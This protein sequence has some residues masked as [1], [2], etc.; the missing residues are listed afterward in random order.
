MSIRLLSIFLVFFTAN[1]AHAQPVLYEFTAT[2]SLEVRGDPLVDEFFEVAANQHFYAPATTISGSFLYDNAFPVTPVG[3]DIG[4]SVGS[5]TDFSASIEGDTIIDPLLA[6]LLLNGTYNGQDLLQIL[7][8][9]P[10]SNPLALPRE[11]VGFDK[12]NP[13]GELFSLFNVRFNFLPGPTDFISDAFTNPD[14]LP[15]AGY[16][17]TPNLALDF[18]LLNQDGSLN[19]AVQQIVFFDNLVITKVPEPATLLL[20]GIGLTGLGFSRKRLLNS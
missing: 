16:D 9:P 20:M 19:E 1:I 11:I 12:S 10:V 6:T 3:T 4:L 18:L 15:P 17:G 13:A 2:S 5:A 14:M 7:I 8:D